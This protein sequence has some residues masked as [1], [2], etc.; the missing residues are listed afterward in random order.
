LEQNTASYVIPEEMRSH[1]TLI[2]CLLLGAIGCDRA[3]SKP[4]DKVEVKPPPPV[5]ASAKGAEPIPV[6]VSVPEVTIDPSRESKVKVTWKTPPGTGVNTD[7]PFK[8]R[9]TTSE[10]LESPP[11]DHKGLGGEAQDGFEVAVKPMAGAHGGSLGGTVDVVVCDS[12][13]HAVCVPV[14]RKIEMS[15]RTAKGA[16][17][18]V[19]V[20]VPLPEARP[21]S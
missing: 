5:I 2:L 16:P 10:G 14:K 3:A 18:I 8:V 19:P 13:T 15:F 11:P 7:A 21:R 20:S 1:A 6:T 12:E 17:T 9:W 4:V